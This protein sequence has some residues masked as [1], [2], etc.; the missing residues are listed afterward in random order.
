M[1][2]LTREKTSLTPQIHFQTNGVLLLKG[3]STPENTETFF[4]PLMNWL[5]AFKLTNPTS[6][7][8]ILELEYLNSP[9][10][11]MVIRMLNSL[12]S[13]KSSGTNVVIT[14]RYD[15]GDDDM[16]EVGTDLQFSSKS[17][18]TF[19]AIKKN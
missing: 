15:D 2:N 3:I 4:L 19:V 17:E 9:S 12:N 5:E 8:F 7:N 1:E 6:V 18:M 13:L 14:W 16:Y 11:K 10:S